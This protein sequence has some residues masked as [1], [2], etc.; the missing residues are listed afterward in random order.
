MSDLCTPRDWQAIATREAAE[1]LGTPEADARL[2]EA[3]R[4]G[5]CADEL[6]QLRESAAE[7][8][9]VRLALATILTDTANALK[10]DPKGNIKHSWH[11]LALIAAQLRDDHADMT[12]QLRESEA[13]NLSLR[14]SI[15]LMEAKHD[16]AR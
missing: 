11:D 2:A 14:A 4:Y 10:G 3:R 5:L 12:R 16:R 1:L 13:R 7:D 15:A 9:G 6:E 8:D